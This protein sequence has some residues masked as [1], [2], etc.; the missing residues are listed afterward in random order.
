MTAALLGEGVFAE[1]LQ[2]RFAVA[3]KRLGLNRRP[4]PELDCRAFAPPGGQLSLL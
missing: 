2:Q 3:C 1:L 4:E